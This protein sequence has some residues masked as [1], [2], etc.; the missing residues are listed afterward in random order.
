MFIRINSTSVEICNLQ[1]YFGYHR[2]IFILDIIANFEFFLRVSVFFFFLDRGM[3]LLGSRFS[4]L[5]VN[6]I[7]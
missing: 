5:S 3:L 1:I 4:L 7:F 6:L 2:G